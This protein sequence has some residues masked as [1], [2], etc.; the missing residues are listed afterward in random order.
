MSLIKKIA[1]LIIGE[2]HIRKQEP[3]GAKN[4]YHREYVGGMWE[5]IG[6]LQF[7]FMIDNGLKTTD[8]LID[9]ACGS[10]RGGIHFIKF[11]DKGHYMGIDKE[12]AVITKGIE[13]ELGP[14]LRQE[15]SP[16][17]IVSDRFEFSKFSHVPT[18]ALAQ[19]L[20]THLA[21]DDI[22]LCLN[23]LR[24]FVKHECCLFATFF[25]GINTV[26]NPEKSRYE[27]VFTYTR[28]EMKNLGVKT[29]WD[30]FYIGE[31]KHPRE[32]VMMKYKAI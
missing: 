26:R 27:R 22:R 24:R 30:P 3:D 21:S 1:A 6:K 16:E 31:W 8:Y 25:E 13:E 18:F 4:L 10:L 32:Q 23:N 12:G 28:D 7:D 11:L 19:S 5:E 15:K 17:F 14:T 20:F 2:K 9:I 29:G